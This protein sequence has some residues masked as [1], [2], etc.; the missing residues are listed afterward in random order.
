[1]ATIESSLVF[2]LIGLCVGFFFMIAS[3]KQWPWFVD[4]PAWMWFFYTQS[5]LKVIFGVTGTRVVSFTFG[6]IF[7]AGSIYI[8]YQAM[9]N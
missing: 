3:C 7:F 5:F 2:G 6:A 9:T 4:P 1:M 8:V